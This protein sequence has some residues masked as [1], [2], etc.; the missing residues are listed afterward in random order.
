MPEH[1]VP[2]LHSWWVFRLRQTEEIALHHLYVCWDL[3]NTGGYGW[4]WMDEYVLP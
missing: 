1:Y 4:P 3:P 2:K